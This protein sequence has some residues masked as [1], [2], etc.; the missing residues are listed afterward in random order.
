L[1]LDYNLNTGFG[2]FIG[3]RG[4]FVKK[5][6]LEILLHLINAVFRLE[7]VTEVLELTYLGKYFASVNAN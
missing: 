2:Y 5:G 4:Q 7:H 6:E 1:T 3:S